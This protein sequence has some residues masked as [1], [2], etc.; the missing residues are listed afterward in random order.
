MSTADLVTDPRSSPPRSSFPI[1][2]GLPLTAIFHSWVTAQA[3]WG[4]ACPQPASVGR[5]MPGPVGG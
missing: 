4:G 5:Q 1:L 3:P 2:G